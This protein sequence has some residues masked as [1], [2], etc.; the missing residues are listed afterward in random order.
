[1][2]HITAQAELS[3]YKIVNDVCEELFLFS[4]GHLSF[5][6]PRELGIHRSLPSTADLSACLKCG[7][8]Q[9]KKTP[10]AK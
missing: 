6:S 5:Q 9:N 7:R 10:F 3:G 1:M 8:L 2:T 4:Q